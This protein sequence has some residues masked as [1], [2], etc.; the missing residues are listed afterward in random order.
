MT[1]EKRL[2]IEEARRYFIELAAKPDDEMELARGALLIAIEEQGLSPK[3]VDQYLEILDE[4]GEALKRR[5]AKQSDDPVKTLVE[6]LFNHIGFTGNQQDYY[7]P[8]NSFLNEVLDRKTGLPI[9]LSIIY[10]EVGTRAG[11]KVEGV[12]LPGH[13]IT[14][15]RSTFNNETKETLVDP[16]FGLIISE[17]DCQKRLDTVYSGNVSLVPEH[18]RHVTNR[19]ILIRLLSNLKGIYESLNSHRQTLAIIERLLLL[20]PHSISE[21]R[22]RGVCLANLKRYKEAIFELQFYLEYA[23][24]RPDVEHIRGLIKELQLRLAALN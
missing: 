22:D 16:F 3:V 7:D 5:L 21:H 12:G 11:M 8:R 24:D 23:P 10:I 4:L 13:F 20:S 6:F 14:R 2:Y 9:T 17:E 18:L 1:P 19:E 15:V